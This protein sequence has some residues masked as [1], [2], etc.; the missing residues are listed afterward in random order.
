MIVSRIVVGPLG[1]NCYIVKNEQTGKG[2]VVDP[3]SG[4][5]KILAEIESLGVEIEYIFLTHAHFDHL[6]CVKE[7]SD[8]T[9]AKLIFNKADSELFAQGAGLVRHFFPDRVKSMLEH[10]YMATYRLVTEGD[11]ISAGGMEVTF[12][13]TPGHT[14]GSMFI[15]CGDIAFTGDT[16]LLGTVGRTDFEESSP[17]D[18]DDTIQKIKKLTG[19]YRVYPGH[20]ELTTLAHEQAT[21]Y[22]LYRA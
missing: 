12:M 18:M 6:L 11:S 7:I 14:G 22:F 3:G 21:N 5:D 15:F 8:A 20:G 10:Y 17:F 19:E 1:T 2:F 4:A 13:N 16:L 9:G